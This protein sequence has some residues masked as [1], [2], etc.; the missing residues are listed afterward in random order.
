MT[1][2]A[3]RPYHCA[4]GAGPALWHLGAL[5]RFPATGEQTGGSLWMH[6]V[7]GRR[8]YASPQHR[9]AREDEAFYVL[10]G[11]LTVYVGDDVLRAE[12]G[13]FLWAPRDVAHAFC[14]ESDE[15]RFLAL[16]TNS[17]LDRFFFATGE[18]APSLTI[19]PPATAP[20]DVA[21]LARVGAEFGVEVL[22]P[23]PAPSGAA[24]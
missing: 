24:G 2:P 6:E 10:D 5:L 15:A 16:S 12:P 9:H 18:P 13:S 14:V 17:A 23:P 3:T 19:P 22:G 1:I 20:P 21:E 11:E 7:R 8:G 4:P